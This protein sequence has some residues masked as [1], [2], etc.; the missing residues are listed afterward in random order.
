MISHT[1]SLFLFL[2]SALSFTPC[3]LLGPAYP[4]FTLNTKD[5]LIASSFKNL[6]ESF[7]Q[8]SKTH[9]G[10]NGDISPNTSF[11]IVIFSTN[12]GDA[13][14]EPFFWQ[15]HYTS[16]ALN[17][18]S[19]E[20]TQDVNG[21]TI[22]RIGGLTELFTVWSLLITQGDRILN[23]PVT[24]HLPELALASEDNR[25]GRVD[26]DH[27]T[28]GQLASHMSGIARDYCGHDLSSQ[29]NFQLAGFP[30]ISEFVLPCCGDSSQ[31]TT[32]EFINNLATRPPV[33]PAGATPSYS[34][35]GYQLL[36]YILERKTGLNYSEMV[37]RHILDPLG[38]N[39]T[40]VFAPEDPSVGV[41]P[42]DMQT[43][44]WSQRSKGSEA[45]TSMFSNAKDLALAG[46]A[47]LNSTLL[48]TAQTRRWLK[49][50]SHTSNTANSLGAPWT[51]YSNG[52]YPKTPMI[53][54]YTLLSN[55]GVGEGLYS[56]YIGLVPDYGIG[57]AI[58]SADTKSPADLNAHAD[59]TE[60]ALEATLGSALA[61]AA[62]IFGGNYT[63]SDNSTNIIP[64]TMTVLHDKLPGLY[65]GEFSRNGTNMR[66]SLAAL[67]G[68]TNSTDLSIRLYPT[69]RG[70]NDDASSGSKQVFRAVLQ[71]MTEF[72]DG[73]TPTCVS[74]M[75]LDVFQYGGR[76]VDEIVFSLDAQGKVVGVDIPALELTLQKE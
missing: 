69:Q 11:S 40:T 27:V 5:Q 68:V 47:I 39:E 74:W 2:F 7:D 31:C 41:I 44:G 60:I 63:V 43:S 16:H 35:I 75:R 42:V 1:A 14:D 17:E 21:N 13:E 33:A 3:P 67:I 49:P 50:L 9:T 58:L 64:S 19:S 10:P 23:D 65:I 66:K 8:L 55:E 46:K 54:V 76:G 71:D 72:D 29:G 48:S 53:D 26:W 57:Y 28:V 62:E 56:S 24:E 15:Y 34:N 37:Q 51:I 45:S 12:N 38:M 73:N 20:D 25:I 18:S 70:E 32:S 22:Y 4:P 61:Q 6:T 52:D 59:Y 36:G 30:D